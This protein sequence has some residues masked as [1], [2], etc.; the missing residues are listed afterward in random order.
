M[1]RELPDWIHGL[2][3][4]DLHLIQDFVLAGGSLKLLA[5]H[6]GVCYRTIRARIDA[7]TRRVRLLHRHRGADGRRRASTW[8]MSS[9]GSG[10]SAG[11]QPAVWRALPQRQPALTVVMA[12]PGARRTQL[13]PDSFAA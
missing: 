10:A 3:V 13:R 8:R 7:L 11:T 12:R 1:Q 4:E 2:E 6:R 9:T 5:A